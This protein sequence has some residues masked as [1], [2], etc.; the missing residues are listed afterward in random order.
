MGVFRSLLAKDVR[1]FVDR[2]QYRLFLILLLISVAF[3]TYAG[4]I[5]YSAQHEAHWE[6]RKKQREALHQVKRIFSFAGPGITQRFEPSPLSALAIG[7]DDVITA[8]IITRNWAKQVIGYQNPRGPIS[9]FILYLDV[10]TLVLLLISLYT[11]FLTHDVL[12]NEFAHRTVHSCLISG[13]TPRQTLISKFSAAF[14]AICI[15]ISVLFVAS[16]GALWIAFPLTAEHLLRAILMLPVLLVY[17]GFWI[18][19]AIAIQ[20]WGRHKRPVLAVG[21]LIWIL[22]VVLMSQVLHVYQEANRADVF[23]AYYQTRKELYLE[24]KADWPRF[25]QTRGRTYKEGQRSWNE[26][27]MLTIALEERLLERQVAAKAIDTLAEHYDRLT[28]GVSP[29][30]LSPYFVA[31]VIASELAGVGVGDYVHMRK[32]HLAYKKFYIDRFQKD[33]EIRAWLTDPA[34]QEQ[35]PWDAFDTMTTAHFERLPLAMTMRRIA[36]PSAVLFGTF[37]ACLLLL[38]GVLPSRLA[39]RLAS[40]KH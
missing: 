29:A 35:P 21:V 33:P 3:G 17:L 37:A 22:V 1:L 36:G 38:A 13:V 20:V 34:K 6:A 7:A 16:V 24:L 8:P 14:F 19:I 4:A 12:L 31:T 11:V 28:E 27:F 9:N 23:T 2:P 10:T 18:A 40:D 26:Q 5:R 15:P 30:Y 25:R 39:K 32:A